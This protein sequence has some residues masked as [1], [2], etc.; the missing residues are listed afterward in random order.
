MTST[1]FQGLPSRNLI[2][3]CH[4]VVYDVISVS[5]RAV[6]VGPFTAPVLVS[7]SLVIGSIWLSHTVCSLTTGTISQSSSTSF[8]G[9][10]LQ[11][12]MELAML[13]SFREQ[14]LTLL[15][16]VLRLVMALLL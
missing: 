6:G 1:A 11:C 5:L 14:K 4:S 8:G 9:A 13:L 7:E 2:T 15:S 3:S 16:S 12:D 10:S